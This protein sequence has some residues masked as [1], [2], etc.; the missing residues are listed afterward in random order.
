MK[1]EWHENKRLINARDHGID[2]QDAMAIFEGDTVTVE[3]DRFDYG[4]RRFM[5]LGLLK[6]NVIA[7]IHTEEELVMRL[8]SARKAT[9]YEQKTFF[10]QIAY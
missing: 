6:G 4:E 3:D 8:I 2:F 7:V 9:K 5:T 1:F 10:E